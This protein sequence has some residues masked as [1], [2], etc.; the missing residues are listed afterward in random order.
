[1]TD[2]NTLATLNQ[3][4]P[5]LTGADVTLAVSFTGE[6]IADTTLAPIRLNVAENGD[7]SL[8]GIPV[9]PGA[10]P[11]DALANL[12]AANVQ[13]LDLSVQP[14]GLYIAANGQTLPTVTWTEDSLETIAQVVGPMAGG[15]DLVNT[16]LPVVLGLGPNVQLDIPPAAGAEPVEVP[17]DVEFAVQPVEATEDSP[18]VNLNVAVGADGQLASL[19]GF[20]AEDFAQLGITL[21]SLPADSLA[22]LHD[23]GV[24]QVTIDTEPGVLNVQFDG[25][26]ALS[27]NFDQ[28]SIDTALNVATPFLGDSPITNPIISQL[29]REQIIPMALTSNVNVNVDLQ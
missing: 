29:L 13:R 5:L 16:V 11:A 14:T 10:V 19:G 8:H 9:A 17:E 23:A 20:T 24:Q 3:V 4:V 21:P 25:N 12:Q 6:Q 27:L 1:V 22:A 26:E 28:S 2:P 15:A 7:V 18:V